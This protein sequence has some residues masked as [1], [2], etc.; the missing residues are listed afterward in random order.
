MQSMWQPLK[1]IVGVFF[2]E[3]S[4][5]GTFR[6]VNTLFDTKNQYI[7]EKYQHSQL[8]L[9]EDPMKSEIWYSKRVL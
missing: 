9:E 1:T 3:E 4:I 7:T 8:R 2:R 5:F 6:A